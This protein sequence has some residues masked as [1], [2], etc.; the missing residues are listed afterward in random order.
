MGPLTGLRIVN[1][2]VRDKVAYPDVTIDLAG[3]GPKHVVV[4]LENGGGKSTLL[5]AIYHVFVPEVDQF[6]PRRAQRRQKKQGD[7]K[8][9]EQYVPGG[10]PTHFVVEI[11]PPTADGTLPGIA[12]DRVLL[13]ACLWKPHGAPDAAKA[14]EF[15]WSVR[16]ISRELSLRE[17]PLRGPSGRLFDHRE[18]KAKLKELRVRV[19]AAQVNVEELKGGWSLHLRNLGIDVEYVQQ[20]LLRM[21]EDE[22]AADQVFTYASSRTFLESLV[23]VV[24]DPTATEQLKGALAAT[25]GDADTVALDRRRVILLEKLLAHTGPLEAALD[26]IDVWSRNRET[27]V[28][29]LV[30]CREHLGAQVRIAEQQ[31]SRTVTRRE[32]ADD[33][34]VEAKSAYA[35]ANARHAL[36]GVQLA[37][38]RLEASN[39]EAHETRG[40]LDRARVDEQ[41]MQCA[42]LLCDRRK[43]QTLISDI[44]D[45]LR[46]KE[47]DAEPLRQSLS[48][49][50]QAL[51]QRVHAEMARLEADRKELTSRL[52]RSAEELDDATKRA[53]S[54]ERTLGALDGERRTLE[55]ELRTIEEELLEAIKQGVLLDGEARADLELQRARARAAAEKAAANGHEEQRKLAADHLAR[56]TSQELNLAGEAS[57]AD[58]EIERCRSAFE[59]AIKRS[60]ALAA[61]IVTSGF[62]DSHTVDFDHDGEVVQERLRAA[63]GSAREKQA[64]AAVA[65]AAAERAAIWLKDHHRLPPRPD[66]QRLCE[67]ARAERLGARPGWTY[68]A[69]LPDDVAELYAAAHPSL[70]DGIVVNVPEDLAAVI[71]IVDAARGDLD[72]PVVIGSPSV[73]ETKG[74]E[75]TDGFRVVLPHRA[76]WSISAGESIADFRAGEASRWR[77]AYDDAIARADL[78]MSLLEQVAAWHR[79]I[80]PGGRE[81]RRAAF[82]DSKGARESIELA[83]VELSGMVAKRA[84]DRD[85][86]EASKNA[87]LERATAAVLLSQRLEALVR[88]QGRRTTIDAKMSLIESE[89]ASMTHDLEKARDAIAEITRTQVDTNHRLARIAEELGTL[90]ADRTY[91]SSLASVAVR[92]DDPMVAPEDLGDRLL[93]V[94]QVREREQRWRG[95]VTDPELRAQIASHQGSVAEIERRLEA[96]RAVSPAAAIT[97]ART[98]ERSSDEYRRMADDVR[99]VVERLVGLIGQLETKQKQLAEELEDAEELLKGLR[100]PAE[101]SYHERTDSVDSAVAI[102]ERLRQQRELALSVQT[103]REYEQRAATEIE[104]IARAR[105]EMLKQ[106]SE[107]IRAHLRTAAAGGAIV[108]AIDPE[109]MAS[110]MDVAAM[111]ASCSGWARKLS[112]AVMA[113]ADLAPA[114]ATPEADKTAAVAALDEVDSE[115]AR[116]QQTLS[117]LEHIAGAALDG[118]EALLRDASEDVVRGD[119]VIQTLRAAPRRSLADLARAHH[120]DIIER[121]VA[122]RHHVDTFDTR[123]DSLGETVYATIA[124]LLREVR[125]TIQESQLPDTPA[126]GRWAGL[127]L[128]KLTGLDT[129]KVDQRRASIGATLRRWFNPDRPED[130]PR[131]FDGNDVVNELLQ[132]VTPQ[133]A[134][135]ILIPSDPLDPEYKPVEHLAKETSGGEGVTVALIL[136]SLLASR[137]AAA[138]GH[139]RTTLL[140]DNPFAKVTK[141]E[142]LRLARDVADEL[143]VQLVAFTGIRDLAALAVFPRLTQL[144]VSRR[145]NANF[146]V[147]YEI[148]DAALQPLLRSGTLYVSPAEAAAADR[149][150]E[151]VWPMMSSVTVDRVDG[152]ESP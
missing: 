101:L 15:F 149:G 122:V 72:G 88:V 47:M 64:A 87:A 132:A 71:Q 79:D 127:D 26:A 35:E 82:E 51:G 50:L 36:A 13:G 61:M 59:D 40:H 57:R 128:L 69:G 16:S 21:N 11:E 146:V 121:H 9:L 93:L 111:I 31:A 3:Q 55:D 108:S 118:A 4:G 138:R 89:R 42:A 140:L 98:P 34:V 115:I 66:V 25:A 116:L 77:G 102:R 54:A 62:T 135:S 96:Y 131:R 22:G 84:T 104:Q 150:D 24:G 14:E 133:F 46:R 58:A 143:G 48:A 103:T 137:R 90:S 94:Q 117:S 2:R 119:R 78:A 139:R 70:S 28:A 151:R 20:F 134:A 41:T 141:P 27:L 125:K 10:D 124:G 52:I 6:L 60:D 142:F 106:S 19:P 110:R 85:D 113:S 107:R 109:A 8:E 123:V 76:Y 43:F 130:R 126:M 83:R 147:P 38:L 56:L 91:A 92:D 148:D 12:G 105:V 32:Q 74:A 144:R 99:A 120:Q 18:F 81:Q 37:R 95:A 86:A 29:Q 39:T 17:I 7:L 114:T 73:F 145:Q 33:L 65:A 100:R 53:S 45:I 68:L 80:G 75:G 129:L 1:L 136:A 112:D 44:N 67:R 97:L 63:V 30:A 5:G 152:G 23:E 49:A